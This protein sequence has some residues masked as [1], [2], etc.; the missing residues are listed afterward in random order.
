MPKTMKIGDMAYCFTLLIE[1]I[2]ED[3]G[4]LDLEFR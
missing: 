2:D 3:Q 1:L 4:A